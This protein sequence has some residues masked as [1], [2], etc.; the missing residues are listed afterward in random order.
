MEVVGLAYAT[1]I[2]FFL[3]QVFV[4]F[5]ARSLDSIKEALFWPT[6]DTFVGLGEYMRIG[7]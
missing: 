5:Y 6:R 1:T 7:T 4:I 3:M 2:S